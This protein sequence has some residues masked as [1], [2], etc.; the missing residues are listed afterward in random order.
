MPHLASKTAPG[1]AERVLA[2][3]D[4]L[5]IDHAHCEKKAAG[6]AI[7]LIFRYPQH[8]FLLEPL[9]RLARE[10]LVHFE[11]VIGLLGRRGVAFG[12][13]KPAPYAGR[14]REA[15]RTHEPARLID[16]L[17]CCALI[18]ARSCERFHLLADT[19]TDPAL[20]DLFGGLRAAEAR[21][22]GVYVGLAE[23][24]APGAVVRDR[25]AALAEHEARVL[26]ESP[27][28]PRMHA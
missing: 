5:L 28:L 22:R 18:E 23:R 14:L 25:L 1:W 12:F 9:S 6:T 24:L 16:T 27:P 10:E 8:T 17:L 21:H 26:A 15:L 20:R 7:N 11:Q 4:E 19:A 13:Q 2:E 3:P